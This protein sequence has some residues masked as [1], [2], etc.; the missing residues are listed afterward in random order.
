MDKGISH[1]LL[2]T[3]ENVCFCA[4]TFEENLEKSIFFFW[5]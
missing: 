4:H 5:S 3:W 2:R 1:A